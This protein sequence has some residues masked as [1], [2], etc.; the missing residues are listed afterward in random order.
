MEIEKR[1]EESR[2][3]VLDDVDA[4]LKKEKEAALIEA[5]QK[6]VCILLDKLLGFTSVRVNLSSEVV[7]RWLRVM[8]RTKKHSL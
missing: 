4:Q 8:I 7:F 2:K 3:K 5:R 1:I 6:E